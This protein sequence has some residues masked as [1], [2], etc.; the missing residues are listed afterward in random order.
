MKLKTIAAT[1]TATTILFTATTA[2]G[3]AAAT[4]RRTIKPQK[5][6]IVKPRI[7]RIVKPTQQNTAPLAIT[8]PKKYEGWGTDA[9]H[10]ITWTT[11]L[12]ANTYLKIELIQNDVAQTLFRPLTSSTPNTGSYEWDGIPAAQFNSVSRS[13]K[14]RITTADNAHTAISE[15][16]TFGKPLY[17]HEPAAAYTW[18]KGSTVTIIWEVVAQLPE[19]VSVDLIDSNHKHSLNIVANQSPAPKASTNKKVP[20]KWTIPT[21]VDPGSYFVKVSSGDIAVEKPIKIDEPIVF[22]KSPYITITN[23]KAYVGWGTDA[24]HTITWN[25]TL[26]ADPNV[27][28]DLVQAGASGIISWKIIAADIPDTGTFTWPGIPTAQ[29][30]SVSRGLRVRISTLDESQVTV[31]DVFT[32]GKPLY[33]LEPSAAYTW[34]KSSVGT[35]MWEIVTEMPQPMR[36]DLLDSNHNQVLNIASNLNKNPRAS[37]NKREV[38][39]WTVPSNLAAGSYFIKLSSG[40]IAMEKPIN[41][42]N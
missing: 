31:G 40:S 21:T 14:V 26:P 20:Y 29:Y 1:L 9:K 22:P 23:P 30:N 42:G 32:F 33:F 39:R 35:I 41:I 36:L 3:N 12:P 2:I 6:T 18:R 13:L 10:T 28:I 7:S 8:S 34:S 38:Y 16:F 15:I 24:Q 27:K 25:S 4:Q 19:S 37:T 11:T 17:L 5:P